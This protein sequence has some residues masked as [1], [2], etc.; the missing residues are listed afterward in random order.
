MHSFGEWASEGELKGNCVGEPQS[1]CVN[2]NSVY[3][4]TERSQKRQAGWHRRNF[5]SCPGIICPDRS[6][7]YARR[8]DI[9]LSVIRIY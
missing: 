6:F 8:P 3:V 9:D 7:L 2:K 4:H 1:F 5:S